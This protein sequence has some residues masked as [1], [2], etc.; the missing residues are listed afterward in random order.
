MTEQHEPME[1]AKAWLRKRNLRFDQKTLY[2]LKIERDVSYYPN[3][4]TIF[5]DGEIA[6]QDERGLR[7]LEQVLIELGYLKPNSL[8]L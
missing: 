6:A 7:G 8:P 4:G 2:Q 5:V 3:K 1:L